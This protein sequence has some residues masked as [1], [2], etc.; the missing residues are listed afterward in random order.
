MS[1]L[2]FLVLIFLEILHLFNFENLLAFHILFKKFLYPLTLSSDNFTSLP[3]AVIE[4]KVNLKESAPLIS[5]VLQTRSKLRAGFF[6]TK[7]FFCKY[8]F[9]HHIFVNTIGENNVSFNFN[10]QFPMKM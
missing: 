7:R 4:I 9:K 10:D 5:D 2:I 1:K 3:G 6:F 8:T